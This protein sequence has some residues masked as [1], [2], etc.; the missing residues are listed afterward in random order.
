[1]SAVW[2]GNEKGKSFN[3][4]PDCQPVLV[5]GRVSARTE[6]TIGYGFRKKTTGEWNCF[7]FGV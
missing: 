4:G 7:P 1:M 2:K 6:D 3:P 5:S